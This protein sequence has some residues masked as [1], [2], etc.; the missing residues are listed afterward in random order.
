MV[1]H[2]PFRNF[3]SVDVLTCSASPRRWREVRGASPLSGVPLVLLFPG[4]SAVDDPQ[5]RGGDVVQRLLGDG[6]E[7]QCVGSADRW[8]LHL[9]VLR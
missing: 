3:K 1:T 9:P 6:V 2:V 4:P 7:A 8:S 5:Y